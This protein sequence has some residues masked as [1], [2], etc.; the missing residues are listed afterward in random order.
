MLS[1]K[2]DG[3]ECIRLARC[4]D[5]EHVRLDFGRT[6]DCVGH[7]RHD[8]KEDR[9]KRRKNRQASRIVDCSDI[10][11]AAEEVGQ[12]AEAPVD[13]RKSRQEHERVQQ[14]EGENAWSST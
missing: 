1:F 7:R 12:R 11:I 13:E 3:R 2:T 9:R 5:S 4:I 10:P 6:G 8:Q 14:S